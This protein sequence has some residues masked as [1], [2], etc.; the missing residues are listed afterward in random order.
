MPLPIIADVYLARLIWKDAGA[1]REAV[2][3]LYF[4]DTVGTQTG[5]DLFN[6]FQT[7]RVRDMWALQKSSSTLYKIITTKLDGSAASVPTLTNGNVAWTGQLTGNLILQGANVI[8]VR[9][10]FR[11]RSRRG[12]IYLPW[13]AE[14]GQDAGTL[15]AASVTACQTAWNTFSAAMVAAGWAPHVVSQLHGDSVAATR[16][17]VE[18]YLKTQRRRSRR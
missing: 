13:V 14:D 15:L 9:T 2:N 5:T 11:G 6:D 12:R 7:A 8:T 18:P 3:D 16:Y 4:K 17:D 10:G 1:P